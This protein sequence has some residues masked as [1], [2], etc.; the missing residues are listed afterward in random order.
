M[1]HPSFGHAI[2]SRV[3]EAAGYKVGILSAGL[4]KPGIHLRLWAGR[5]SAFLV[6]GGNMDS[7]VNHYSVSLHR[8]KTDAFSPGGAMNLRPDRATIVYCNLIRR[9]YRDIPI[10]IGGWRPA[11]GGWRITT[12]GPTKCAGPFC[13]TPKPTCFSTA[14]ANGASGRLQ[15]A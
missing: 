6:T 5:G 9:S 14:W 12:I 4:E 15:T 10:I 3:L 11:C 13:W 1:D 7:M 2:I 8:R